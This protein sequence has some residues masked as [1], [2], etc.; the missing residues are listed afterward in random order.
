MLR[1]TKWEDLSLT[2]YQLVS[3]VFNYL[4]QPQIL[5]WFIDKNIFLYLYQFNSFPIDYTKSVD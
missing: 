4:S 5:F 1:Y 3:S 2:I